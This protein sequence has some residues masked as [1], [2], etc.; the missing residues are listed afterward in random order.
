[1]TENLSMVSARVV[2]GNNPT[3][4]I[5]WQVGILSRRKNATQKQGS[6]IVFEPHC[7]GTILDEETVLTAGHCFVES[8]IYPAPFVDRNVTNYLLVFATVKADLWKHQVTRPSKIIVP[9]DY[10]PAFK[11]KNDIA[12][13]KL[14]KPLLFNNDRKPACLP[15]DSYYP[16]QD[17]NCFISGWGSTE[18]GIS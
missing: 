15:T 10:D 14:E 3:G 18:Q 1:M 11:L 4:P 5:P 13:I 7:G 9:D 12:I 2:K 8:D 6:Q 17:E 16:V